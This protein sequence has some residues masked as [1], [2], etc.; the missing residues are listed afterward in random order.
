ML[1]AK[2]KSLELTF[3][4]N[5]GNDEIFADEYSITIA[6]SNLIDNAI[7]YTHKGSIDVILNKGKM[8][9]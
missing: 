6:I 7:K 3:Q 1:A 4:N 8:M 5:C 2:Y 9:I